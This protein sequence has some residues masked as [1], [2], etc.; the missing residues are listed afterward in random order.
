MTS[1]VAVA[2]LTM[3]AVSATTHSRSQ[4]TSGQYPDLRGPTVVQCAAVMPRDKQHMYIC[5]PDRILNNSQGETLI[6]F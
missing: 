4:W 6:I 5:D 1:L 2:L 3:A